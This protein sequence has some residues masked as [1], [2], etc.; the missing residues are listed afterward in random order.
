MGN[1]TEEQLKKQAEQIEKILSLMADDGFSLRRAAIEVGTKAQTFLLW[2]DK[3]KN[4]AER[5][6]RARE[7]MI[8]YIVDEMILIADED[9]GTS[10]KGYTDSGMIQKQRL[11]VDTRK[12]LLSKLMPERYG[13]NPTAKDDTNIGDVLKALIEKLPG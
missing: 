6:A 12:W 13:A 9:V 11:Q 10:D 2:C 7:A 5:Y 8:D 4:L 3:D 1:K